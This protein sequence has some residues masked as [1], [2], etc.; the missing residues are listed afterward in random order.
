MADPLPRQRFGH[1]PLWALDGLVRHSI[2]NRTRLNALKSW[3]PPAS[4]LIDDTGLFSAGLLHNVGKVGGWLGYSFPE[5][6]A[7]YSKHPVQE[8]QRKICRCEEILWL[9]NKAG[10]WARPI[11]LG[12]RPNFPTKSLRGFLYHN[13]PHLAPKPTQMFAAAV[14]VADYG[15]LRHAGISWR[16]RKMTKAIEGEF[17]V[18]GW[19]V[20]GRFSTAPDRPRKF[21]AP[22]PMF[23]DAYS[24]DLSMLARLL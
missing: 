13:E 6:T 9:G 1:H 24:V 12:R 20:V 15:L 3:F 23:G 14:Q 16:I 8:P 17:M 21:F 5:E 10:G 18:M 22:A 11:N 4:R 2:G 19:G 7:D